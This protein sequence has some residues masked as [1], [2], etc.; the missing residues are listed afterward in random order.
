MTLT[1]QR[2]I[3]QLNPL[4]PSIVTAFIEFWTLGIECVKWHTCVLYVRGYVGRHKRR[5]SMW[6][7]DPTKAFFPWWRFDSTTARIK[8]QV[9]VKQS[10]ESKIIPIKRPQLPDL[11][12]WVHTVIFIGGSPKSN[13]KAF[14]LGRNTISEWQSGIQRGI[15]YGWSRIRNVVASHCVCVIEVQ[16]LDN[17]S[18]PPRVTYV[19]VVLVVVIIAKIQASPSSKVFDPSSPSRCQHSLNTLGTTFQ[20]KFNAQFVVSEHQCLSKWTSFTLM[21]TISLLLWAYNA[22][23]DYMG[24]C[25]FNDQRL[26]K[27][28][29]CRL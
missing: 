11:Y 8:D 16:L 22:I 7:G 24:K 10:E 12:K 14:V 29:E 26:Y 6:V 15:E 4:S 23:R 1:G 18:P 5:P 27:F 19:F 2:I 28:Y 9:N 21:G 3:M 13:G 17:E 20:R 25:S